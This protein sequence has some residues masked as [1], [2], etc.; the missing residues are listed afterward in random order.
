MSN[1]FS[2]YL[3]YFVFSI[4]IY[5]DWISTHEIQPDILPQETFDRISQFSI[6]VW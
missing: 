5:A 6:T 1:F 2:L 4:A 3:V